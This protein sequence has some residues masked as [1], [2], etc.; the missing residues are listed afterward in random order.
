MPIIAYRPGF[1]YFSLEAG[2]RSADYDIQ[3]ST[4]SWKIG[5]SW[6]IVPGFRIR[7]MEQQ[8]VRVPNTGE[9][10]SPITTELDNATLDP[11]SIGNPNPPAPG[12]TLFNL[13][14]TSG[15]GMLPTQVGL[16]P[17]IISG[18]INTFGGTNPN[19]LPSPEEASTTTFG[20]VWEPDFGLGTTIS[21]DY[22]DIT[23]EDYIDQPTGQESLDLCYV[24]EDP[25]ICAGIVRI[26][27]SFGESATGTP[28]F[29]TNFVAFEAEGIDF[30]VSSGWE[31]GNVG[32]FMATL[33]LHKYL[34]NQFQT[35][36]L[37]AVVDCKGRYGTSCDP[38]PEFRSVVRLNWVRDYLDASILWRYIDSMDAQEGE[39]E[40]LFE[41]FRSVGSESYFDLTFGYT[42]KDMARL[43]LLVVNVFDEDPPILGDD[44][45]GTAANSGNTFPSLYDT[46]GRTYFANVKFMF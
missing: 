10:F 1:E 16:V 30:M 38:V 34:T 24:L 22:Y 14:V 6:E 7:A 2:Y 25:D 3:G 28:A 31:A 4:D 21:V 43:S 40:T 18:Q 45:G 19:A 37:S 5:F 27:G 23:I 35:T 29:F 13:C 9:L 36:A 42:Y 26:G 32:D 15:T 12:S 46:L 17:D 41:D 44:T 8:A 11:C 33:N 20:F 39:A